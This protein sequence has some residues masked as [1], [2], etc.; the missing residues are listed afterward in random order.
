MRKMIFRLG[1]G[2]KR[3]M[4]LNYYNEFMRNNSKSIEE[5]ELQ[6]NKLLKNL[7][8][9]CFDH[10]P[11]YQRLFK[12]LHLTK[13]DF[14]SIKDLEKLP[15]LTKDQIKNEPE[16][17]IPVNVKIN[18]ING[19]TGGST[20][21]PLK[22]RMSQDCYC[23][24]VALLLRGW[25]FAGYRPSD[26][27]SVIAGASLV[28][29][30]ET[31]K[32]KAQ[33]FVLNFRHYSS[34]G[35]D[36]EILDR[37]LLHMNQWKPFYLR[38]YASSLYL[39][40][41][42]VEGNSINLNFHLKGIFSTA[43]V[44]SISQRKLIE[45][46]FRV[47]VFDNYGLNDGGVSAYECDEHN[48]MHIDYERSI[49]QTVDDNWKVVEGEKG[50]IIATSLYNFA[51][52]FIRYD[53]GDLGLID[54]SNCPCGNKRPLL[55]HIYGRTTDYLKLNNKVIGSPVLTVLMGKVDL[56]N[57]QIMQKKSDEIDVKYVKDSLL[58]SKDEDFIKKSF[59]EHVGQIRINFERVKPDDLLVENKYKFIIN[60]VCR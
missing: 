52:P 30:K 32:K 23:K 16:S 28:S 56:E 1:Y 14:N 17:F 40:A 26:K 4:V 50:K 2:L 5:L 57:Y 51:M 13:T 12:S 39:L 19:S 43:E 22:Y 25:G 20:G 44:L 58:N 37:Y 9:F 47:K 18:F 29:N 49:L 38:G 10:V 6:Q 42:Y 54:A 27:L 48:G 31:F 59:F 34:Y 15:I 24:G 33:D 21:A 46:A 7:I 35:M 55:K 3:P 8:N 11:Y 45:S 41:K 36:S 53:T 60:E